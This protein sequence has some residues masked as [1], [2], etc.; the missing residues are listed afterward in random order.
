MTSQTL[1]LD[2]HPSEAIFDGWIHAFGDYYPRR[3]AIEHQ[4]SPWSKAVILAK[5]KHEN[6]IEWF[7]QVIAAHLVE[8]LHSGEDYII[9]PV[10]GDPERE[11]YLFG[12]LE[13]SATEILADCIQAGMVGKVHV[14]VSN[15][16]VQVRPKA[17]RQHQCLNTGERIINVRGLYAVRTGTFLDGSHVVLVDDVITSGATMAE[18]AEILRQAGAREVM[19][20]ALARTVRF[21]PVEIHSESFMGDCA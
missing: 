1:V 17:K 14:T 18:C 4:N 6:I 16:L 15:L 12:D 19:G 7:G 2:L 21:K 5:R 8:V 20:V 13:R 9:T 11:R 3:N 10:P